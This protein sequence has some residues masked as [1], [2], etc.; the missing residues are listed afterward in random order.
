MNP[1]QTQRTYS[2]LVSVNRTDILLL[3]FVIGY[4]NKSRGRESLR[5]VAAEMCARRLY[6]S[7]LSPGVM[8]DMSDGDGDDILCL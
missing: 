1:A 7:P 2:W 5:A 3:F 4:V 6:I 8:S